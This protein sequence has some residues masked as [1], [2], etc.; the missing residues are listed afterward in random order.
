MKLQTKFS[1]LLL[2]LGVII[3]AAGGVL[4]SIEVENYF[5]ERIVHELKT[6]AREMEYSLRFFVNA[7]PGDEIPYEK[8]QEFSHTA[9]IRLTLIAANGKVLFDSEIPK[10]QINDVENHLYRPEVQN[11]LM[12]GEGISQRHSATVNADMLYA[13]TKLSR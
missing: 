12:T 6:H 9:G 5:R 4:S 11:A 13:A 10:K 7:T 2:V 1:I 8:I 3:L